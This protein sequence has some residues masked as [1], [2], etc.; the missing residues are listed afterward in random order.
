MK[1]NPMLP[2]LF[3]FAF[4]DDADIPAPDAADHVLVRWLRQRLGRPPSWLEVLAL[5]AGLRERAR[6]LVRWAWWRRLRR[7]GPPR[8]KDL[9]AD[10]LRSEEGQILFRLVGG[11]SALLTQLALPD[12]WE[13][14]DGRHPRAQR[15][16]RREA[17]RERVALG[18][19]VPVR[20][21][22]AAV[23]AYAEWKLSG[24]PVLTRGFIPDAAEFLAPV[25]AAAANA[26]TNTAV[27]GICARL[28]RANGGEAGQRE[29]LRD[30]DRAG[31]EALRLWPGIGRRGPGAPLG[32]WPPPESDDG[33]DASP[34][35][36]PPSP[37][38]FTR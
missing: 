16:S 20:E 9:V 12:P 38:G 28:R 7:P 6:R 19:A 29:V 18:C 2:G 37:Q 22:V 23:L 5:R 4:A 8:H 3:E 36:R 35:P 30:L 17:L 24:Q 27:M 1:D 32:L 11:M 34:V 13:G 31:G 21:Q 26:M 10:F 15:L 33:P 25:H 14:F